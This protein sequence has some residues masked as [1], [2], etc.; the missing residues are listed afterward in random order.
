MG[1]VLED[2]GLAIFFLIFRR[3]VTVHHVFVDRRMFRIIA[4]SLTFA[5]TRLHDGP[6]SRFL[7]SCTTGARQKYSTLRQEL[8][9]NAV[10][11]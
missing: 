8:P 10:F 4:K 11:G 6:S 1:G 2:T 5:D 9:E 7:V 3:C